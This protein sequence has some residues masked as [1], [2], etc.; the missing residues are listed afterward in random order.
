MKSE[1]LIL[2][3]PMFLHSDTYSS[4]KH[5]ILPQF[6]SKPGTKG[7]KG[8]PC[9]SCPLGTGKT[10]FLRSS[11]SFPIHFVGHNWIMFS[12]YFRDSIYVF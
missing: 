7:G 10:I 4:I 8:Q 3:S 11:S 5:C 9:S 1:L 12:S 6:T 2:N